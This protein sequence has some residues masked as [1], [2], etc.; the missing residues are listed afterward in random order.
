MSDIHYDLRSVAVEYGEHG[1]KPI[2]LPDGAIPIG[3]AIGQTSVV[4]YLVQCDKR[5]VAA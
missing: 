5:Q 4:F 3:I 1:K 2:R